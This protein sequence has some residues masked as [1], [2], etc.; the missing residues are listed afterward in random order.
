[1]DNVIPFPKLA[2]ARYRNLMKEGTF[3]PD[4]GSRVIH[5][6]IT[7]GVIGYADNNLSGNLRYCRQLHAEYLHVLEEKTQELFFVQLIHCIPLSEKASWDERFIKYFTL[8]NDIYAFN[9][10]EVFNEPYKNAFDPQ[11]TPLLASLI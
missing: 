2:E 11:M 10:I 5:N 3:V 6:G 8:V 7:Y 1:M 4:I 9:D